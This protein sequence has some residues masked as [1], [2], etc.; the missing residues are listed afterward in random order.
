MMDLTILGCGAAYPRPGGACSGYLLQSGDT[1]VWLEA[2]NGT[3][4]RLQQLVP[5]G[6][7]DAVV[8]SHSHG[9]H[10]ADV[11]PLMYA[12]GFDEVPHEPLP[13]YAP[14]DVAPIL[15]APLG[16]GSGAIF[17]KVFRFHPIGVPF[18]VGALRFAP[19]RT[20]HPVITYG[21]RVTDGERTLVYSADTAFFPGLHERCADADLLLC[22]ATFT[23]PRG[24]PPGVHLWAEETGAVAAMA[25]AKRLLIT[26]VW[27]ANDPEVAVEEAQHAY[28]GPCE[29]AVEEKLYTV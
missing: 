11:H 19:F 2:G 10:I 17:E 29:A 18:E 21:V 25:G 16:A 9:D 1:T 15:S 27:T 28:T 13:V 22:E 26:H 12:L 14:P 20:V 4:S 24:D 7:L 6:S 23:G 3:F 5:F 8:L